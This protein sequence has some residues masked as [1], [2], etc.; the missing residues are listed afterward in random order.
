MGYT[1][2]QYLLDKSN[3]QDTVTQLMHAFDSRSVSDLVDKVYTPEIFLDYDPLMGGRPRTTTSNEWAEKV[4][5][6]HSPYEF[7]QHIVL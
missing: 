2:E 5:D 3:I 6:I 1:I 4:K 7:T